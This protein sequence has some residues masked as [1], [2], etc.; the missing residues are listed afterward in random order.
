MSSKKNK[1]IK[2][3]K[4]LLT[5]TKKENKK[6]TFK[7]LLRINLLTLSIEATNGLSATTVSQV[8]P[9]AETDGA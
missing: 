4:K 9:A 6:K 1:K 2:T 3:F 5:Q 8:M 7:A